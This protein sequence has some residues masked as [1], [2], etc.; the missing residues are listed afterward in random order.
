MSPDFL[1]P[2]RRVIAHCI[3]VVMMLGGFTGCNTASVTGPY[4]TPG[5]ENHRLPNAAA[6]YDKLLV[7]VDAVEGTAPS[8]EELVELKTFLEEFTNKKGGV[9][10]KIDSV[11]S[12]AEARNRAPNSLAIQF[13]NGP[14]DD[15]TAFI[16]VLCYRSGIGRLMAKADQPNFT[17]FPYPCAIFVDRSF[18]A[19][20]FWF[21]HARMQRHMLRHEIG[22]A[23]GL[24]R[25]PDH[26]SR[27]HCT[28][29]GCIMRPAINFNFRRLITFR[30]PLDNTEF[31]ADCRRDLEH[32]KSVEPP[33]N[34]RLWRGYF[35]REGKGYQILTLPGFVYV[36]F[37]TLA[38][39]ESEKIAS[40]RQ[41][42]VTEVKDRD[43]GNFH[44]SLTLPGAIPAIG[45]FVARE[46]DVDLLHRVAEVIF[47]KSIEQVEAV[48]ATNPEHA[49]EILSEHF[50]AAAAVFPELQAKL[51]SLRAKLTETADAPVG[52]AA[53][54]KP[55]GG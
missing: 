40:A 13:L 14:P 31:C 25:N 2:A 24:A 27:G 29:D 48:Q 32:Y 17:Y 52:E 49:R 11:I 36:H 7:E 43:T 6:P 55:A 45:R 37:G 46:L 3:V 8:A 44:L 1:F 28:N 53:A 38:E 41:E 35:L 47:E 5:W 19:F 16:Y 18:A 42:A 20:K 26:A 22:H 10:V 30:P 34:V 4:K 12:A 54:R 33:V 51:Q 21:H 39:L 15:R 23:L 9:I 50:I